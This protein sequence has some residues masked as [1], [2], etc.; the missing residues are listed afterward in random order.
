MLENVLTD[1][2]AWS[3]GYL[4]DR[5]SEYI[6]DNLQRANLSVREVANSVNASRP[7][8]YR[9][10]NKFGGVKEF[11]V[12]ERINAAQSKLR[13]GRFNRDFI[14]S[15]VYNSG[16]SSPEPFSKVFKARTGMTPT[17]FVRSGL[18]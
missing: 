1:R 18:V 5:S 10:F 13:T 15:V 9:A 17:R 14:T 16:L 12:S 11:I 8:L 3:H 6:R 7:M 4:R 2:D